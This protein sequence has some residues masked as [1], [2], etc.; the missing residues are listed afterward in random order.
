LLERH[1]VLGREAALA[2]GIPGGFAGLYGVLAA[3]EG[4]GRARRG[5]FVEG[6]GA[7]Q[8]ALPGALD[9]LRSDEAAPV[10][11]L[12]A[13]DPAN[14]LGAALPWPE[15]LA[16]RPSRS[17]GAFVILLEGRLGAFIERGGRRLLCFDDDPA[18]LDAIAAALA[19]LARRLCRLHPATVDGSP[20]EGTPLGRALAGAG[21]VPSYRGLALRR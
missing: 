7:A 16:G 17:A 1:G 15:H 19:A 12:A 11:T 21:F 20:V 6:L 8:F 10:T 2:E 14:P 4:A 3:F 13:A 5:Y 18:A 9:R